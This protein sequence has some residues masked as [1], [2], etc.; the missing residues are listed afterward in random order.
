MGE[1]S[2]ILLNKPAEPDMLAVIRA[3]A[4][5]HPA[6]GAKLVRDAGDPKAKE[7]LLIQCGDE[8]V[9]VMSMP[10]PIPDDPGLWARA[11]MTWPEV[12]SV[13]ARHKGHIIV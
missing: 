1:L 5:R 6:L 11:E 2:L 4:A 10:A 12:G 3:L 13:A 9:A 7:S 8:S